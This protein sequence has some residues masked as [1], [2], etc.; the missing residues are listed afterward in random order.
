MSERFNKHAKTAMRSYYTSIT[1]DT[2]HE[3]NTPGNGYLGCDFHYS[4]GPGKGHA[5]VAAEI[6]PQLAKIL[7]LQPGVVE[8]TS[9]RESSGAGDW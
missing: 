2:W 7:E 9:W 6:A 4:G 5:M 3:I 8:S 1:K